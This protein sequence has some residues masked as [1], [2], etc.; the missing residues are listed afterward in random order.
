MA[1]TDENTATIYDW[2]SQN[3]TSLCFL[4]NSFHEEFGSRPFSDIMAE[5]ENAGPWKCEN[6][7]VGIS[8]PVTEGEA[9]KNFSNDLTLETKSLNAPSSSFQGGLSERM[10][11]RIGLNLPKLDTT[12]LLPA[13]MASSP[14]NCSPYVTI[15]PGLSPT[16]L[17]DSPVFLSN[18]MLQASPTTGKFQYA[19]NSTSK[20]ILVSVSATPT[21]IEH[22]LLEDLSE[23]FAFY[24]PMESHSHLPYPGQKQQE[25][26]HIEVSVQ[27]RKPTNAGSIE[28]RNHYSQ[29]QQNP[30]LQA[31]FSVPADRNDAAD[32]TMLNQRMSDTFVGSGHTPAV[33]DKLDV[34]ADQKELSVAFDTPDDDVYN[35]R[36][37]GQ[38]QVKGSEYPRS[39]Y[40][41]THPNCQVKKKVERSNEG[42][43]TE[44]IYKGSHNHP[45]PHPNRRSG[46]S[47][48]HPFSDTQIDGSDQ[49][50]LQTSF[51]GKTVKGNPHRNG[52]QDLWG[53]GLEATSSAPVTAE[54]GDASKTLQQ[55]QD[56]THLSPDAIG[57]SSTMSNDEEDDGA[58]HG[59]VSLGCDG[60]ED[61]NESRRRKL[62]A[63]AM[64][65]NAASRSTR[66]PRVVVQTT[67]EVDILDDGYRWRKY[68]QKVVKGN[69]NPRSYYK[70]TN[71]G[72]TVRK[73]IERAS[74]DLKSVITTYEGRHNHDVPA[75]RSNGHP[76]NAPSSTTANSAPQPNNLGLLQRPEPT[77]DSF[78]RFAGYATLNTFGFPGR[79]HLGLTTS[80]PFAMGQPGLTSFSLAGL[81]PMASMKLP[82]I[83]PVN[84]YLGQTEGGF[85]VPKVER[86]EEPL[87]NS[88]LHMSNAPSFH[89]RTN[90]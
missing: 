72:C 21:K 70:C 20:S 64:E 85:M 88:Q 87:P 74:H 84:P 22:E 65:M 15:P 7:N 79:E 59:S 9:G 37:Y 66:E 26:P 35:W 62:D 54:C 10:S 53:G 43:I 67:S 3:P 63:C 49:P 8:T 4:S 90:H 77:Q 38:K 45:K 69:P 51:E 32:N 89:H 13:S 16:F 58:T 56:G 71:P 44:I 81:G 19:G 6:Q 24:P 48:P 1:G 5:N 61:E 23:A 18:S 39:Y 82:L 31:F 75:A 52:G 34:E 80:F 30:N 14:D 41:C 76:S 27:P 33:D 60:D 42:H 36:K 83:P 46:L 86:K 11:A 73:H 40:K 12:R 50:G 25:L 28:A 47:S 17:L 57:I 68:G 2:Q 55:N 29:N 78:P